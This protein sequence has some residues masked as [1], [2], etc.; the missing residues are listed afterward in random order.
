MDGTPLRDIHPDT[1]GELVE[2]TW[3]HDGRLAFVALQHDTANAIHSTKLCVMNGD[4]SGERVVTTLPEAAQWVSW[5]PD[6]ITHH[7]HPYLDETPSWSSDGWIYF[8][9]NRSGKY[10]IYRMHADGSGQEQ[11]TR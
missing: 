7:D 8:Q 3:S 10:A 4:G 1:P 5:S 11:L 9:S 6:Q 2:A